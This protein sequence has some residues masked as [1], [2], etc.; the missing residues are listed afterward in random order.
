MII[1]KMYF[2]TAPVIYFLD[3]KEPYK[4]SVKSL[5]QYGLDNQVQ[6]FS[7]TLLNTEFLVVPFR[8]NNREKIEDFEK[9]KALLN[10]TL[11]AANAEITTI[12]AKL[13]AKYAGLKGMDAIHLATAQYAK[14]DVFLTNDKQLAQ[15]SEVSVQVLDDL[16]KEKA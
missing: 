5:I 14:C 4:Q 9:F 12:A 15:I 2:D 1:D 13:R 6:F 16:V 8:L 10:L 3:N 11:V 7:S